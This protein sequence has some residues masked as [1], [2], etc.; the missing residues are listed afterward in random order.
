MDFKTFREALIKQDPPFRF[1][2][3]GAVGMLNYTQDHK[4]FCLKS[5]YIFS[6]QTNELVDRS[7]S[8]EIWQ[9]L[10]QKQDEVFKLLNLKNKNQTKE[11][12]NENEE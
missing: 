2:L 10:H 1:N 6:L 12:N 8:F 11:L 5:G 7:E 4:G 3:Q 9:Y